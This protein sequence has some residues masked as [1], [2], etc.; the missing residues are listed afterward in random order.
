MTALSHSLCLSVFHSSHFISAN[1]FVNGCVEP[2]GI[3]AASLCM[4]S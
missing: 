4:E 3:I 2:M 1:K